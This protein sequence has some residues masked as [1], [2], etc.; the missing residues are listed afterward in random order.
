MQHG[1]CVI[2][3]TRTGNDIIVPSEYKYRLLPLQADVSCSDVGPYNRM[4][5]EGLKSFGQIDFLVNCA[6]IGSV[7]NFEETSEETMRKLFE[8][9]L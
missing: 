1:D 2:A 5:Q 8:V 4:V 9:N 6:G 3:T 7:T